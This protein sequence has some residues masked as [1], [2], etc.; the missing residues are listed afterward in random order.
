MRSGMSCCS[1][2]A[3]EPNIRE[4]NCQRENENGISSRRSKAS[5]VTTKEHRSDSLA[6]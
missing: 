3:N 4:R 6:I 1:L 2:F 5:K